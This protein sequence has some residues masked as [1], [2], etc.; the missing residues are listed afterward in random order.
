[1]STQA[2]IKSIDTLAFVKAALA[3]F[4]QE[5]GQALGEVE[6]QAARMADWICIDQ[7]AYWKQEVRKA[8]DEIGR[9]HV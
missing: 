9:A 5:S 6:L 1:M 8:A 3:A 4:A 7:A 2:E